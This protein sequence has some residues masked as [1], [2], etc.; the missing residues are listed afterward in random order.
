MF[1]W[2]SK[3]YSY[4]FPPEGTKIEENIHQIEETTETMRKKVEQWTKRCERET[5]Q[6]KKFLQTGNKRLAA[7]CLKRKNQY[8]EEIEKMNQKIANLESSKMKLER[9]VLDVDT[10]NAQKRV[11]DSIQIVY[12]NT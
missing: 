9:S 10:L 8:E 12:K 6:A 4:F 5:D 2:V 1:S 7:N 3:T 11:S